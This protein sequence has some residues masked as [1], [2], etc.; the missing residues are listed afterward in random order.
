VHSILIFAILLWLSGCTS[1]LHGTFVPQSFAGGATTPATARSKQ[2]RTTFL[3]DI[4]IDDET[5]WLIGYSAQCIVVRA[6]AYE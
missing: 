4:S 1:S 2:E 6:T 5:R 3:A